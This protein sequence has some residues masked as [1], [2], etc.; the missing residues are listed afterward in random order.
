MLNVRCP[1]FFLAAWGSPQVFALQEIRF[2]P[3]GMQSNMTKTQ[4]PEPR[5]VDLWNH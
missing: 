2:D 5:A 1:F 4:V 3:K